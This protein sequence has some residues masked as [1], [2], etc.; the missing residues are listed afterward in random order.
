[1]TLDQTVLR[2]EPVQE[3]HRVL[4]KPRHE[5]NRAEGEQ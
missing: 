1:M 5:L 2:Q 3:P 4:R